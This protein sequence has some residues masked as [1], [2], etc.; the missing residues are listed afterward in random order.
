MVT[1]GEL[2]YASGNLV[3]NHPL[4]EETLAFYRKI[5]NDPQIVPAHTRMF[6]AVESGMAFV[7]GEA[8]MMMNW[9]SWAAQCER[10]S[11]SKVKGKVGVA[12]L[13]NEN[14]QPGL[15]YNQKVWKKR[16]GDP[17]LPVR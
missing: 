10:L 5:V 3:L 8:A 12:H 16:K 13:P 11:E 2:G 6:D 4:V 14:E 7:R 9:F 15:S 1:R 17:T